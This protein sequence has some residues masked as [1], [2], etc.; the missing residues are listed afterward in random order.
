SEINGTDDSAV[1]DIDVL[2][3]PSSV[4]SASEI[5]SSDV[6]AD[7]DSDV[8]STSASTV[9]VS[10]WSDLRKACTNATQYDTIYV[11]GGFAPANQIAISKSV[12]IEGN[13][14][15]TDELLGLSLDDVEIIGDSQDTPQW[16]MDGFDSS[17]SMESP[18]SGVANGIINW[19]KTYDNIFSLAIDKDGNVLI[20]QRD[21]I[22][23]LN[24]EG[25]LE[26]NINTKDYLISG[27]RAYVDFWNISISPEN[28]ITVVSSVTYMGQVMP[29]PFYILPESYES[30]GEHKIDPSGKG[31]PGKNH[32]V[33]V[34]D[35]NNKVEY[36]CI[37]DSQNY[38]KFLFDNGGLDLEET[39]FSYDYS[40]EFSAP[41][42]VIATGSIVWGTT[43]EGFNIYDVSKDDASV[44][45]SISAPGIVGTPVAD[46]DGNVY[47]FT[48][49]SIKKADATNGVTNTVAVTD[50]IG[51]R[52]ALS[53][54]NNAL[55]SVNALGTLYKYSLDDLTETELT[56]IGSTASTIM[57]D[58]NGIIYV[59]S[60]DGKFYAFDDEG[61]QKWMVDTESTSAIKNCAMDNEGNIYFY[62]AENK[63]YAIGEPTVSTPIGFTQLD[64]LITNN[65][66]VDLKSDVI[67]AE[68]ENSKYS[69][70][71]PINKNVTINGN[72]HII[73]GTNLVKIFNI[74]NNSNVI[75]K[76]LIITG[77]R[78]T[79]GHG[80]A[81][82]MATGSLT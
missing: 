8:L 46:T 35:K 65:D 14:I 13:N 77:A 18:Y 60:D 57:T 31:I 78:T 47:F 76:D 33:F 55:Y 5:N 68:G 6:N 45:S 7:S 4:V 51:S 53:T 67:L 52:M 26:K 27:N 29:S 19:N 54:T 34:M 41:L 20:G 17:N 16:A 69:G 10:T 70:G 75:L 30:S 48:S 25:N 28:V 24:N 56:D 22:D 40:W 36:V 66:V 59:G 81:I 15:L 72:N 1:A 39:D 50:G 79:S 43:S 42:N 3:A 62:T 58:A 23:F 63:V 49:D 44:F 11:N 61:N 32:I 9:T 2:S 74:G 38:L 37:D 80:G 21:L 82:Y 71:I 64:E 12:T 73:N